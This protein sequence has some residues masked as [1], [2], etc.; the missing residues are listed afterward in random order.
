M[1]AVEQLGSE[2]FIAEYKRPISHEESLVVR[3]LGVK[4]KHR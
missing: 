1:N 3:L 2:C 4:P